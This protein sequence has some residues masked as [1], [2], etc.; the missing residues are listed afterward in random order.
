MDNHLYC[1][2]FSKIF[3]LIRRHGA[4]LALPAA[5][6][7]S[8]GFWSSPSL[9]GAFDV[10]LD[11]A[12]IGEDGMR[13][14][15]EAIRQ[16]VGRL[17]VFLTELPDD[18]DKVVASNISR[19]GAEGRSLLEV[20]DG[21]AAQRITQV[22]SVLRE[23]LREFDR[24]FSQVSAIFREDVKEVVDAGFQ[25]LNCATRNAKSELSIG[26]EELL[27]CGWE[28]LLLLHSCE[29]PS[30]PFE[31]YS[32]IEREYYDR[33]KKLDGNAKVEEISIIYEGLQYHAQ[34]AYCVAAHAQN[35]GS[36]R[37]KYAMKLSHFNL[38]HQQWE[39]VGG[40]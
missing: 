34:S 32:V 36:V 14:L 1:S 20:I 30:D 8:V 9:A 11:P 16:M 29:R 33:L 10:F 39:W 38:R 6:S 2:P 19:M 13:D 24:E 17:D 31:Q 23:T 35:M 25:G 3:S 4:V 27:P 15:A 40:E 37:G 12:D 21:L 28:G 26:L 5:I 18:V 22:D 7:L